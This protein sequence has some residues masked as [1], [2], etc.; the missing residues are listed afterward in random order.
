MD[1]R[2]AILG[3]T[4][5]RLTGDLDLRGT[6]LRALLVLL[7]LHA[8]RVTPA[9]QLIDRLY[10]TDPPGD[11]ANAL[12]SQISRLRRALDRAGGDRTLVQFSPA[13]YRLGVDPDDVD[14][15]RFT[16]LAADGRRALAAGDHA[17]AATVLQHALGLW[18]GAALADVLD[19]P[20][21]RPAAARLDEL[22]LDAVEDRIEADLGLGGYQP[23][24][25][26]LPPLV[27]AHPLR[28]R[29]HGQLMRALDGSGRRAEALAA[30][31]AA[32]RVLAEE[33]GTDP[34]AELAAIHLAI[35]RGPRP[36]DDR[37]AGPRLPAQLTSFVGRD[38]ELRRVAAL[39]D[40]SRLVTLTGP[41]GAGKTRLALEVAGRSS[42][43]VALAELAGCDDPTDVPG[44]VLQS[45]G[46]RDAGLRARA[47]P[48]REVTDRLAAALA[49]RRLLLVLDNCEHVVTGAAGLADRLL[50][51]CPHLRIL[52]TSREPLAVTGE[53][54]CPVP[55]LTLPPE[56]TPA[57]TARQYEAVRLFADRATDVAPHFA[58]TPATIS[59][60]GHICRTLDGL[61]LAIE[62]A[63]ARLHALPVA[64]IAARLDDR[65]RLLARGS[66][67]APA[68]H[69]TLRAVVQWSWDLLDDAERVLARRL[70]VFSGGAPLEAVERVCGLPPHETVEVL[71]GLVRQSLVEVTDGRYR[72]LQT[73]RAFGAERL[74]DAGE[75]GDLRRAHAAYTLDLAQ[76][77][78]PQLRRADQLRWLHRLDAERD[79]LHTAVRA[80]AAHGEIGTALR[81]VAA[82]S[83][84]WWVRGLRSEAVTLA[85]EVLT[86]A[87]PAA[88]PG[89]DED[90]ALCVLTAS[91]GGR[92]PA[93]PVEV[94]DHLPRQPFLLFLAAVAGGPPEA[95]PA[96][97]AAVLEQQGDQL[98]TDPWV[99]ALSAYGLGLTWM[100]DGRRDRAGPELAVA[101]DGFRAIG[102]RWGLLMTLAATAELAQ[103]GEDPAAAIAPMDEALRLAGELGSVID[104]ADLLRIR[105]DGHVRLGDLD[106]AGSDYAAAV[107]SARRAGAP[108]T[109]AAAL[110]GLGRVARLRD[111]PGTAARR[112]A[113]ALAQCPTGW[114]GAEA[115]RAD[116]HVALGRLAHAAGDP[117][118]ARG[119][120]G[121]ALTDTAGLRIAPAAG[122]AVEGLV[123]M[124]LTSGDGHR[125]ALL[126][127]AATAL[128]PG[129]AGAE[130]TGRV[131]TLVGDAAYES[132]F[133]RGAALTRERALDV[134]AGR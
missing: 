30:F 11:A 61:P 108:E 114:F 23:L 33:L 53:A 76:H 115:I 46:L 123:D 60:V 44:A 68:R 45:L 24:T 70:T 15:H 28:E 14:A 102:E 106:R 107:E 48:P 38:G 90:F 80:A 26:E 134:I 12:Q 89:H 125:A 79:N 50:R 18:R 59:A 54:L 20:F 51:R 40:R 126:L 127:G 88:P 118:A 121:R 87:G 103:L 55:G 64:E 85:G 13:G 36:R 131:R 4:R 31:A 66:R 58:I 86:A 83:F 62:L 132:A 1:P 41:G 92:V 128:L 56:D 77:A 82:L 35:L 100:Y 29:L 112:Y 32:R 16:R 6:R 67:T 74:A 96:A 7:L 8:P 119:W 17:R 47:E 73:V 71:S 34:S 111:D 99:R 129:V 49:G 78:D 97:L 117:G 110:A 98:R 104:R 120:Y 42:T 10:G 27:A 9:D 21:A 84:Y 65:F 91:L 22:R 72:M 113:E 81:L 109:T 5:V 25:V 75:A 122:Q 57:P 93:P 133:G 37:P 43:E 95:G 3:P 105:G 124:E 130:V 94:R 63:A 2:F 116:I 19:A 101:R 69:R 39:L 52:A